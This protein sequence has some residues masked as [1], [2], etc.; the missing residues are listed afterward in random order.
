ME[1]VRI[2][3]VFDNQIYKLR[4][5]KH[6]I[7]AQVSTSTIDNATLE[8]A[9]QNA[10]VVIGALRGESGNVVVVPEEMVQKMK[11]GSFDK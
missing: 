1:W 4:R 3:Q 8:K 5:L 7:G 9:I 6:A 11:E 10:D 2:I